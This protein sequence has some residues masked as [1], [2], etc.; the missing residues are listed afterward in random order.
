[1]SAPSRAAALIGI[2]TAIPEELD[3]ILARARDVRREPYRF[4]RAQIGATPVVLT[5]AGD[6]PHRGGRGAAALCDV[7]RPKA[8]VGAGIAGALTPEL[9]PGEVL[10][11]R[12]VVDQAG[13]APAPDERLLARGLSILGVHEATFVTTREP[14]VSRGAKAALAALAGDAGIACV[15]MESAAWA[16]E[17][18]DRRI[19]YAIVRAISDCA[20]EEL[21]GYLSQCMDTDGS[22][23]RSRVAL[24]ALFHPASIGTLLVMRRRV[25]EC[26]AHLAAFLEHFLAEPV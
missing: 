24:R 11:A 9:R 14:A 20:E 12:R 17:A 6:G 3:A 25:R 4:F 1:M 22:I 21:P 5:V 7:Y 8:L 19:P 10:V 18:A 13:P 2:V 23:R 15:D 26:G 16:R